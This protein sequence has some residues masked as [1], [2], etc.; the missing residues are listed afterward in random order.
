MKNKL[1]GIIISSIMFLTA[2]CPVTGSLC[3]DSWDLLFS[4]DVGQQTG[5]VDHAGA[6]FDGTYFY[7]TTGFTNNLIHQFDIEGNLVKEFSISGVSGLGDLAYDGEY[8]YGG[9]MGFEIYQMDFDSET[10]VGTIPS[11]ERVRAIAYNDDLDA[12][13]VCDWSFDVAL[14]ARDGTELDNFNTDAPA[15]ARFGLA[16]DNISPNGPYLWIFDQSR[17]EAGERARVHQ[18]N[19]TSNEYT[20]FY[21]DVGADIGTGWG[22]AKG[23]F[24]T[25]T[26]MAGKYCIGGL[27]SDS[28]CPPFGRNAGE[29]LFVYELYQTNAPPNRPL[30][31]IGPESGIPN[32]EYNFESYVSDPEGEDIYYLFDWGDG[33]H[34]GWLGPVSSETTIEESNIWSEVGEFEVKIKAKD[35]YSE[36]LWSDILTIKISNPP[37]A[38]DINGQNEGKPDVSYEFGFTSTDP[39]ADDIAEYIVNWGD[40]SPDEILTGPFL[41]GEEAKGSHSWVVKGEFTI[42]A[43]AKDVNGVVGPEA[44]LPINIPRFKTSNNPFHLRLFDMFPILQRILN[45]IL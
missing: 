20:G 17:E 7:T 30:K 4:I 33:S 37:S 9:S 10:L 12:F 8:F 29:F 5:Y 14:I 38:P 41:S 18:W 16:Y 21:H 2:V 3:Y 23:L 44:T 1:I 32:N 43:K 22:I 42:S 39:D 34:S 6:E 11:T 31:P 25:D 27:M 28:G 36:S 15:L 19:L 45:I 35:E 26:Y 40:G 24:T 13:Y